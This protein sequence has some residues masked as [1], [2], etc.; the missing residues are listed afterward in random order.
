MGKL[1]EIALLFISLGKPPHFDGKDYSHWSYQMQ[2]Y[3]F[4]LHPS[5]WDIVENG[6]NIPNIDDPNYNEI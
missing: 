5:I 6:M 1:L 4:G 3:L 2:Y